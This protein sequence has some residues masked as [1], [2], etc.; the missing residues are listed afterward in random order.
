MASSLNNVRNKF[1]PQARQR[2][3]VELVNKKS[4]AS[5]EM[6]ANLL[7]ISVSTVR[8]DL[9][10]LH[11]AGLI[12]RTHGGAI[13]RTRDESGYEAEPL[14]LEKMRSMK[15]QKQ[16]IA[17]AALEFVEDNMTVI[18]DSGTTCLA[19]AKEIAGRAITVIAL[20]VKVAEAA[21]TGPTE[22]WLI[23]GRVRSGLYSVIGS[24]A[25]DVLEKIHADLLF[26]GADAIDQE[27]ITN[28]TVDEAEVKKL[29][30]TKAQQRILLA[31]HGKLNRRRLV[32]VCPLNFFD[33][34]IT[35]RDSKPLLE[36]Y[37]GLPRVIY[38]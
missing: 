32:P 31:D 33:I 14:F 38:A 35:D 5:V 34:F 12:T 2:K 30:L 15:D 27:S 16:R 7:G 19:L 3:I 29:A 23:G 9:T 24:W 17:M 18:I 1:F 8:R 36:A 4:T 37:I 11:R 21:A 28:S 26:L 10:T 6:I 22:V 13:T 25:M 20:D